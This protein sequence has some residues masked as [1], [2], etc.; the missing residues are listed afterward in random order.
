MSVKSNQRVT[1]YGEVFTSDREVNAMLD[2]V[3]E[4]TQRI[5]SRFLEPACGN[6]NFLIVVLQRKLDAIE[7]RCKKNR[8]EYELDAIIAIGSIYGI[9]LLEDNVQDCRKRLYNYFDERYRELFKNT[10]S[11][12][13]LEVVNHVLDCNL[14]WGNALTWKRVDSSDQPIIFAE[15]SLTGAGEIQRKDY[16]MYYL[17]ESQPIDDN[18]I[19][20]VTEEVL[21]P[22]SVEEYPPTHYLRLKDDA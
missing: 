4:E 12:K 6:G 8:L 18:D 19:F 1:D 22:H 3:L 15:W 20:S 17:L 21:T 11:Q 2:L 7:S 9:D 10:A 5:E 16:T 14:M 13:F